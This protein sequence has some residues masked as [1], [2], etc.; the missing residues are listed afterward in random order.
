[1]DIENDTGTGI[2]KEAGHIGIKIDMEVEKQMGSTRGPG[3]L[4]QQGIKLE[5]K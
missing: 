2:G 3:H 1:M 4:S 5:S